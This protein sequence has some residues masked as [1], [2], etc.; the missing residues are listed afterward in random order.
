[1]QYVADSLDNLRYSFY[2]DIPSK[3]QS[4]GGTIP[5]NLLITALIPDTTILDKKNI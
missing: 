2:V 3:E 5:T 4:N 1:M